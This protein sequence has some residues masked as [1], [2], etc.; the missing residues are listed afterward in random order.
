MSGSTSVRS[1]TRG[2]VV[3]VPRIPC[4]DCNKVV[5]MYTSQTN[6]HEGWVF[7]RCVNEETNR[8]FWHWELEYVVYLLDHKF[9]VGD[10]AIEA[11]GAADERRQELEEL[12]RKKLA[13]RRQADRAAM[14]RPADVAAMGMQAYYDQAGRARHAQIITKQEARALLA[15]LHLFQLSFGHLEL[16]FSAFISLCVS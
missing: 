1:G 5:K 14:G 6:E 12:K 7:Y 2:R 4:P 15:Q 3:P 13:R 16:P 10:D 8:D 11:F 9:L